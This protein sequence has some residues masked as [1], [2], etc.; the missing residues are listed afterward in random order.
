MRALAALVAAALL[1][2]PAAD[3]KKRRHQPRPRTLFPSMVFRLPPAPPSGA[4]T[5]EPAPPAGEPAPAPSAPPAPLLPR[6]T[7]V[8]LDEFYVRPARRTLG[9][10]AVELNV[11]NFGEDPHDLTIDGHA[12]VLLAPGESAQLALTLAAGSYRLY[13]SLEGHEQLGMTTQ[14][15][16]KDG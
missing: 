1:A 12:Q 10:G 2:V 13:C 15:L 9:S 3:A 5:S 8:D 14:L 6:R 16:V 7:A 11:T 4:S